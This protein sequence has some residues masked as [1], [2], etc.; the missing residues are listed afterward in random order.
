MTHSL[1][2]PL[3]HSPTHALTHYVCVRRTCTGTEHSF[4]MC[5]T[6]G[7][8]LTEHVFVGKGDGHDSGRGT[9]RAEDAQGT[10]TQSHISPSILVY[11]DKG[12][13]GHA[14]SGPSLCDEPTPETLNPKTQTP[15]PKP[16]TPNPKPQTPNRG[17]QSESRTSRG[18]HF[19]LLSS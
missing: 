17:W 12:D 3:T 19:L 15:N 13:E 5:Q 8:D 9:A 10:P 16:Q 18:S 14:R 4:R 6:P 11:E 1:T 2:H 7:H